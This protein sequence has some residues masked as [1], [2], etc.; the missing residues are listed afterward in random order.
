MLNCPDYFIVVVDQAQIQVVPRAQVKAMKRTL[1]S[2]DSDI[3][4]PPKK[5]SRIV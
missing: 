1:D 5:K 3:Q 4:S 2:T